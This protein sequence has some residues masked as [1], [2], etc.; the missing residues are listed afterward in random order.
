MKK[1]LITM[2]ILTLLTNS[3]YA[4]ELEQQKAEYDARAQQALEKSEALKY[5]IES[6][7]DEKRL[8]DE[9]ADEAIANYEQKQAEL[10]EA[11]Y[12]IAEN[13]SKLDAAKKNLKGMQVVLSK[14]VR[15]IY[16]NGQLNYIDVLFGA[17]D[18]SDFLTRMDL[19]K[20]IISQDF[21][22]VREL[23][24]NKN[25]IESIQI[26][27]E[28]DRDLQEKLTAQAEELKN[29]QIEKVN[30]RQE[31]IES[32][33]YDKDVYDQQYQ[34]ML[35]ASEYIQQMIVEREEA[36]RLRR[37]AAEEK[38]KRTE[39]LKNS[40]GPRTPKKNQTEKTLE[41][42]LNKNSNP[43]TES[44]ETVE[45]NLN[46]E[47][48]SEKIAE[49]GE[50]SAVEVF[51]G[52]QSP[53]DGEITSEFGWRIH[54]TFGER[55]FHSG[56]DIAAEYGTPILSAQDGTVSYAGWISG[57]GNTVMIDHGEGITTL[58]GHNQSLAVSVGD[59]VEQGDIIAFCGS[60]GNSTGPHCHF[61]VRQDGEPVSPWDFLK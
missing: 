30:E 36:D 6:I 37:E 9:A 38:R 54:P 57:Y 52:M 42:N 21:M 15:D 1:V 51:T 17:S 61:E 47:V 35:A 24:E 56:I 13:Q 2:T 20:R 55:I 5:K 19:F 4:D 40:A 46:L 60:T 23:A 14:R 41:S 11:T 28:K 43:A 22:I 27:L 48:G 18:F 3:T 58:Y 26:L 16:I 33:M 25:D 49:T 7:S 59:E 53:V 50:D 34:E 12:R 31:L 10:D 32:M 29:I 44:K 39:Q 8:L 45:S